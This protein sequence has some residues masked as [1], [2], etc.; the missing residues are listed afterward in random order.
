MSEWMILGQVLAQTSGPSG[1][2]AS[3]SAAAPGDMTGPFLALMLAI[4]VFYVFLFRG[5][6]KERQKH[7]QML[8]SLKKNDRV[9]TIGGIYG[10][11]VETRDQD[12]VVKV[13]ENNN[14]KVRFHRSSIKEVLRAEEPKST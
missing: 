9:L 11:V 4:V 12:V 14:V 1:P 6:K 3:G 10:T 13:D 8:N 2:P 5:Q 7:E